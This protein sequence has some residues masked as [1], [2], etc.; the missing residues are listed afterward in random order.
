[1]SENEHST[2]DREKAEINKIEAEAQFK[3]EE[4]KALKDD[5][6]MRKL[7]FCFRWLII[8]LSI[9]GFIKLEIIQEVAKWING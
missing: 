6:R 4:A 7:G 2:L 1:M 5:A 9:G 8:W 3:R